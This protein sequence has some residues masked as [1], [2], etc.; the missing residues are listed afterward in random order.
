MRRSISGNIND[1]LT[2][3]IVHRSVVT[4]ALNALIGGTCSLAL[5]AG[6]MALASGP[7]NA[8]TPGHPHVK[9][10]L[11]NFKIHYS[12][13]WQF[14]SRPLKVCM[15]LKATGMLSYSLY[16]VGGVKNWSYEWDKQKIHAPRLTAEIHDF[17]NG[18]CAGPSTLTKLTLGQYWAGYSCSFNP[19]ISISYPY[20]V[21]L[22]AW[23]SCKPRRQASD[24]STFDATSSF[25]EQATTRGSVSYG[26]YVASATKYHPCYG[27]F[28]TA[29]GYQSNISDAFGPGQSA[30]RKVCL[31]KK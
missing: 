31:T 5:I 2:G 14:K 12:K 21:S 26:N 3:A 20:G 18:S 22:S 30:A 27:V 9:K 17:A 1:C 7:A 13:T 23:P 11:G 8:A 29:I 10:L 16:L 15:F 28:A 25:Y 4:R 24:Q 6:S 19:Q